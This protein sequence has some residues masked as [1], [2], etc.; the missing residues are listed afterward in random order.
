MQRVLVRSEL[1]KLLSPEQRA[2]RN[3]LERSVKALR[4]KKGEMEEDA[5]YEKLEPLL[6]ELAE[7]YEA[8]KSS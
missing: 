7:I 3:E 4:R 6:I 8:V 5:Y 1:E 2:R